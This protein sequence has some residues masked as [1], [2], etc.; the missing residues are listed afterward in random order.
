MVPS[1]EYRIIVEPK[2]TSEPMTASVAATRPMN[3]FVE[4]AARV[5][6]E[7]CLLYGRRHQGH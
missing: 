7:L 4:R 2:G 1:K 6:R 5:S 3:R